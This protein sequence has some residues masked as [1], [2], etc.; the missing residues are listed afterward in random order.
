[1]FSKRNKRG[2]KK[3]MYKNVENQKYDILETANL[4][5]NKYYYI[6]E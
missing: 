2:R 1:M 5:E 6:G 4:F 3:K